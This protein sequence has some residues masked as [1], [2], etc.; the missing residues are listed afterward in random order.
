MQL[1]PT[2]HKFHSGTRQNGEGLAN[3]EDEL[4]MMD[5]PVNFNEG[6]YQ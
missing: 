2:L 6:K 1:D 3:T 5:A 4:K